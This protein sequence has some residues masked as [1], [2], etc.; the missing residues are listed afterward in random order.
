MNDEKTIHSIEIEAREFLGKHS[1][2]LIRNGKTRTKLEHYFEGRR[3]TKLLITVTEIQ[4][5]G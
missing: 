5:N 4:N 1:P 3:D 2:L